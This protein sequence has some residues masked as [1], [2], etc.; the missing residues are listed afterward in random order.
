MKYVLRKILMMAITLAVVSACVFLAFALI[1]GDPATRKL[2]T[3]ATPERIA[4]LREEMGLNRPLPVR[5]VSWLS[6]IFH[7]DLGSSYFY[8][9]PVSDLLGGKIPVTLTLALLAFAMTVLIAIP[10]GLYTAKYE[11][12]LIDRVI[13]VVNQVIMSIPPFF[14]G[15][16][17][18]ALFGLVLRWFRPGGFVSYTVSVPEFLKYMLLPAFCVALP[19]AAMAVKML[20]GSMIDEAA[21]DYARTAYSR[22]NTIDGVMYHHLLKN[23]MIPVITLLGMSLA[24]M[25]AGSIIIEQI[26]QIPGI[27]NILISS[28]SNRDYPVVQAIIMGIALVIILINLATDLIYRIVDP[29]LSAD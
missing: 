18:S 23:A 12:S 7:G 8:N 26:F 10:V 21:K 20:R 15:I 4:Q 16:L 22:G 11:G 1:P 19:K 3:E 27:S 6:G 13:V 24:D 14:S 28:I 25:L 5:Y 29:R 9:M 17:L 2:G